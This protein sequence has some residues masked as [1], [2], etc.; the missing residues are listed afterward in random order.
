MTQVKFTK[1]N[2]VEKLKRLET[3]KS[4]SIDE[5]H[6]KFVHEVR[7]EI[8]EALAEIFHKSMQTGDVPQECRD[9]LISASV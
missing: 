8:G 1:E 9:S 4:P 2:V 3:D 5:L 6:P 7:E